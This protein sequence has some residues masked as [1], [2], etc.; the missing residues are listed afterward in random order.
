MSK[1][2]RVALIVTGGLLVLLLVLFGL[3][4][5]IILPSKTIDVVQ[6]ERDED[7]LPLSEAIE[8]YI[9]GLKGLQFRDIDQASLVDTLL[10]TDVIR[11]VTI[12]KHYSGLLRL[13]I[14]TRELAALVLSEG[15]PA[16]LYAVFDDLSVIGAYE[17]LVSYGRSRVPLLQVGTISELLDEQKRFKTVAG[18]YLS[19][20]EEYRQADGEGYALIEQLKYDTN[21]GIRLSFT[22]ASARE[23]VSVSVTE[24]LAGATLATFLQSIER[25]EAEKGS[26]VTLFRT[27]ALLSSD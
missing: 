8:R 26:T 10:E 16:T 15:P 23:D 2:R 12:E 1:S 14:E 7:S 24:P 21:K 19:M 5:G 11:Q 4:F 6:I 20:L 22:H 3:L 17:R 18:D 13:E 9:D 27:H 25:Y